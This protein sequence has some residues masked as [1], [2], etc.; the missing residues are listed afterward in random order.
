[1]KNFVM[2][3][4]QMV[5]S[6]RIKI[7]VVLMLA[8]FFAFGSNALRADKIAW[9]GF[10]RGDQ[11]QSTK[12]DVSAVIDAYYN[13]ACLVDVRSDEAFKALHLATAVH[14][15]PID[16]QSRF[17]NNFIKLPSQELLI[18][19]SHQADQASPREV[20][21]LLVERGFRFADIVIFEPGWE[22]LQ[23]QK[24]IPLT[25]GAEHE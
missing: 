8:V 3:F 11:T 15:P 14:L 10:D 20:K 22:A 23:K 13:G 12:L 24:A 9:F 5:F 6:E 19:Y 21:S 7:I 4:V 18:I 17:E 2:R 25:S 1:M 16:F